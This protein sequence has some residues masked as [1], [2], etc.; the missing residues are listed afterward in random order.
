MIA[1]EVPKDRF[2]IQIFFLMTLRVPARALKFEKRPF[3][4]DFND[5]SKPKQGP[6]T[7]SVINMMYTNI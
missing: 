6:Y 3:F 7:S 5:F 4:C 2:I 1:N